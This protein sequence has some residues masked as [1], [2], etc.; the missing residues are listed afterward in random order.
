MLGRG[1]RFDATLIAQRSRLGKERKMKFKSAWSLLIVSLAVSSVAGPASAQVERPS[2]WLSGGAQALNSNDT[3]FPDHFVNV[4]VVGS[5]SYPLT[6]ILSVEGEFTWMIPIEQE[7]EVAA[8]QTQMVK[9]PDVLFYQGNL[10]A[11]LPTGNS[12]SPYVVA[13]AGAA[14]FL[15]NTDSNRV[16]A[17]DQSETDFAVNFGT[18]L[19]YRLTPSW[20]LR[21]DFREFVAFPKSDAAGLSSGG[22]ADEVWTERGTLGLG[23]HF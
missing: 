4:P 22:D 9:T 10:K 7:A 2:V 20:S 8:G 12:W 17:L 14:T 18:G 1:V 19:S 21:G 15:S 13:G 23:Y 16:P 5:L 6:S 11:T 3:A